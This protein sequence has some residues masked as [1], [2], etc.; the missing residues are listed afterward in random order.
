LILIIEFKMNIKKEKISVKELNEIRK[1]K[2][3]MNSRK[4]FSFE[5]IFEKKEV[6]EKVIKEIIEDVNELE[7]NN[8]K[9]ISFKE[10][11]IICGLRC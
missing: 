7:K 5:E 9:P 10:L 2:K 4:N 8:V 1:I 6:K 11:D 3:E